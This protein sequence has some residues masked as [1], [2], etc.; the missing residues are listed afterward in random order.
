MRLYF[1]NKNKT[2][3]PLIDISESQY[4]SFSRIIP[5]DEFLEKWMTLSRIGK[6]TWFWSTM[7]KLIYDDLTNQNNETIFSKSIDKIFN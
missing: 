4:R 6:I 5:N 3:S 1:D 2:K 7:N